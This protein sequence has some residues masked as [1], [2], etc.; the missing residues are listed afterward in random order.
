MA[1]GDARQ[2][3]CRGNWRMELVASTLHTT[4]EH[5]VSNITTADAHTSA[6][7]CQL[8]WRPH[9]FKWTRPFAERRNVVSARVPSHFNFPLP[10][11]GPQGKGVLSLK[12]PHAQVV[13]QDVRRICTTYGTARWIVYWQSR[14]V[15][16]NPRNARLMWPA[17]VFKHK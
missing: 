7:G 4:S 6:A 14:P 5:V 12:P 17:T 11:E 16:C 13:R 3:N 1:H 10:R 2:G 8:N 15:I 9:R